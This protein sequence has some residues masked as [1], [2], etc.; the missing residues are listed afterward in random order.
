MTTITHIPRAP[1]HL[2]LLGHLLPLAANTFGF[3]KSLQPYGDLVRIDLGTLPVYVATSAD[4][5][6]EILVLQAR[7]VELGRLFDRARG[8]VG[9]GLITAT[10]ETHHQHRRLMQPMVHRDRISAYA[11]IM[12]SQTQTLTASWTPGST[13]AVNQTMSRLAFSILADTLFA[14]ADINPAQLAELRATTP[15]IFHGLLKRSVSPMLLDRLPIPAVRRF[16]RAIARQRNVLAGVITHARATGTSGRTDLLSLLLD[17]RTESGD[18]LSDTEIRD[19]L[20]GILFAGTETVAA[21]LAWCIYEI[22]RNPSV[23]Q[24]LLDE[25]DTVIG[26]GTVTIEKIGRLEY[27]RRA[28]EEAIRLHS[29]TLLMRR[30][31]SPIV[32]GDRY[33]L[34]TG[35]EIAFSLYALHQDPTRFPNP[36]HFDPDRW[37]P[38]RRQELPRESFIPFGSGGR[39]CI[40]DAF[41]WTEITIA[42]AV[43][44]SR[45]R[46]RPVPGHTPREIAAGIPVPHD[47]PMTVVPRTATAPERIST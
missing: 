19:E 40:G 10:G 33:S 13:T 5:V 16:D 42:L 43:I 11:E 15:T 9:N 34:P 41:A 24:A 39:K 46:L 14:G 18:T 23:E 45:W 27:T 30:T 1:G 47:L 17:A 29:I 22:A 21:T 32:L 8:H 35:T 2:P 3:L 26:D 20:V 36:Q 12:R 38:D 4:L 6:H 25:I 31:T 7:N 37:L 28:M 44:Y